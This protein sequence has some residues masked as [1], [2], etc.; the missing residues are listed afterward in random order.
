MSDSAENKV[1]QHERAVVFL[2]KIR[3]TG[4]EEGNYQTLY[5]TSNVL[6]CSENEIL[7]HVVF[8]KKRGKYTPVVL[9][10]NCDVLPIYDNEAA[11]IKS[12]VK[13]DAIKSCDKYHYFNHGGVR[14]QFTH[15]LGFDPI[16]NINH[17]SNCI[18]DDVV[19]FK[20]YTKDL[21]TTLVKILKIYFYTPNEFEYDILAS[22]VVLSYILCA[23][24]RVFYL[25]F[26]GAPGSGKTTGLVLLSFLQFNG[27]F[28]GKGTVASSVRL[29]HTYNIALCQD[30]FDKMQKAEKTLMVGVF[31][32]GFNTYGSYTITNT[33]IK[34]VFRQVCSFRTFGC[35]GFTANDLYGFDPSFLD[36][37]YILT[38]MKSNRPTKD[39]NQLSRNQLKEFQ[40][41]RDNVFIYCLFNWG[42]IRDVINNL[43]KGLEKEG[44]FGR[45][46]D[47]NSIILGIIQHF[48]G[49]PY[50]L[51]VKKFLEEKAPVAQL[52]RVQSM[53]YVILKAI[54]LECEGL[55]DPKGF[56]DVENETLYKA[57]L[58]AFDY[59]PSDRYAPSN[60][61]PRSILDNLNLTSKKENLGWVHSGR[62]VYHINLKEF[63]YVLHSRGYEDILRL[64]PKSVLIPFKP[65]K[66]LTNKN[67]EEYGRI[68]GDEDKKPQQPLAGFTKLNTSHVEWAYKYLENNRDAPLSVFKMELRK[69]WRKD[70]PDSELDQAYH[71]LV[72]RL[73]KQDEQQK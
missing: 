4:D 66:P 16:H 62:R 19:N 47:K 59:L 63:A 14:Y 39:I 65:S 44:K 40:D 48:K 52:E 50:M 38:S 26:I 55:I 18:L 72:K 32:S 31:N 23:L 30:E 41:L 61:K 42:N 6:G 15:K 28:G 56:V 53:E 1:Q 17:V 8:A 57:L 58:D 2:E 34:D 51:K 29:L 33:N 12:G 5:H 71:M 69:K 10:S 67:G 73:V 11:L 46:S 43:K 3:D 7:T 60:Q 20:Q 37:C 9:T 36:R 22:N 45:E 21:Y 25:V 64:L 54:A 13:K 49:K 68:W 35:K 27:K 70:V 24:G